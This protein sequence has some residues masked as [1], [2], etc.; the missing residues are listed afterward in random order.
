MTDPPVLQPARRAPTSARRTWIV[1]GIILAAVGFLLYKG[2][3]DATTY[4]RNVDEALAQRDDLGAKRFR[5]QGTVVPG[6]LER[7][8]DPMTFAVAFECETIEVRHEGSR[9]AGTFGEGLPVVMV[10][11]FD[12]QGSDTFV[13]DEIIVKHTEEYQTKEAARIAEA[14]DELDEACR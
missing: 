3:G 7:E 13:S 9:P 12:D 1:I 14:E 11:A 5:L 8:A 2:L 10:G 6:S 4:F